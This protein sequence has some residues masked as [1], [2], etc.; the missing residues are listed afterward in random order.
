MLCLGLDYNIY[1]WSQFVDGC[2]H[3]EFTSPSYLKEI[4]STLTL[5]S[6]STILHKIGLKS[7]FFKR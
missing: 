3:Q 6:L 1:F 4:I 7:L 2:E 5:K